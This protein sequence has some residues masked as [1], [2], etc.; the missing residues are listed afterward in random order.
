M[1]GENMVSEM[2]DLGGQEVLSF[3]TGQAIE[4]PV[5]EAAAIEAPMVEAAVSAPV[6]EAA[7]FEMEMAGYA[8]PP[9]QAMDLGIEIGMSP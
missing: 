6:I 4:A 9:V 5:I 2:I 1:L 3:V 8:A 7:S